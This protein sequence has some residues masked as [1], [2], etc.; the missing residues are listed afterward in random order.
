MNKMLKILAEWSPPAGIMVRKLSMTCGKV[1]EY[2]NGDIFTIKI[3]ADALGIPFFFEK[4]FTK[5]F[6]DDTRNVGNDYSDF[7]H[8]DL[9]LSCSLALQD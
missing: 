6:V 5:A 9:S 7:V 2:G 3:D 4:H 1:H 8:K